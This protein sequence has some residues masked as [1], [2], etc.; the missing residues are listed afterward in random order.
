MTADRIIRRTLA[1]VAAPLL[2]V[3]VL[4]SGAD[5]Q[6]QN[7]QAQ[8][9]QAQSGVRLDVRSGYGGFVRGYTANPIEI[10]I[11]SIGVFKG[12]IEAISPISH[13]GGNTVYRFPI[14]VPG[15]SRKV[16][17]AVMPRATVTSVRA[18]TESGAIAAEVRPNSTALDGGDPLVGVLSLDGAPTNSVKIPITDEAAPVVEVSREQLVLGSGGLRPLS[19]LVVD[20]TLGA[21]LSKDESSTLHA[22]AVDGGELI[23]AVRDDSELSLLSPRMRARAAETDRFTVGLGVVTVA[24]TTLR[25][26][27]WGP[28]GSMWEQTIRPADSLRWIDGHTTQQQ[29]LMAALGQSQGRVATGLTWLLAFVLGYVALAGPINFLVL[30]RFG[31]RELAWITIPA[32]AV[33]FAGGAYLTGIGG[34]RNTDTFGVGMIMVSA[35]GVRADAI[36]AARSATGGETSITATDVQAIEPVTGLFGSTTGPGAQITSARGTATATYRL[37][38]GGVATLNVR[39]ARA[40]AGEEAGRVV[41][42]RG[43]LEAT[44]RNISPYRLSRALVVVGSTAEAVGT[45]DP[46]ASNTVMIGPGQRSPD[47]AARKITLAYYEARTGVNAPGAHTI[48]PDDF[49]GGVLTA[50]R[51]SFGL[52]NEGNA[53]VAGWADLR[54]AP[55]GVAGAQGPVLVV[56]PLELRA[57][58]ADVPPSMIPHRI[59][60]TDGQVNSGYSSS[61]SPVLIDNAREA[62]LRFDLPAGADPARLR[63]RNAGLF[64]TGTGPV[65]RSSPR[66]PPP[67]LTITQ[68]NQVI[69]QPSGPSSI[70]AV[71]GRLSFYDHA[72]GT[73]GPS[74]RMS[75]KGLTVPA[76]GV[77]GSDGSVYVRVRFGGTSVIGEGMFSLRGLA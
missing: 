60:S 17:R 32:L 13:Q 75:R 77:A 9:A 53:F 21:T 44:V 61:G 11:D 66:Q 46:G 71:G 25:S 20:G 33:V 57:S 36:V 64:G 42:R 68:G 62:V 48:Y 34:D 30:A 51:N 47:D 49:P 16:V 58:G 8:N 38:I 70:G 37:A 55:V 27:E 39:V 23:V 15:G 1:A 6:A 14:E 69:L 45:L 41:A 22:F 59:V 10:T 52:T 28:N 74:Q 72:T 2:L 76:D 26:G 35:D 12:H 54:D 50:A 24:R 31:R 7:A 43:G 73:W 19:H 3:A 67:A 4:P 29:S 63:L 56:L 5:A 65:F 40:T 18:V